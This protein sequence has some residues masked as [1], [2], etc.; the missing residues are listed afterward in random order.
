MVL[1]FTLFRLI[2]LTNIKFFAINTWP[3]EMFRNRD[4]AK[5]E[6]I[7]DGFSDSDHLMK[8]LLYDCNKYQHR[9]LGSSRRN[10]T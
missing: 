3:V 6:Y 2:K 8:E 1:E 4:H 10:T 5:T 7:A 9:F